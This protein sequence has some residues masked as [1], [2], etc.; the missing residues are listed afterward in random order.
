M[1]VVKLSAL[2]TGRLYPHEIFLVLISV[3]GWVD[4]RA[5]VRPEE[6]VNEKFQWH[7]RESKP[8]PSGLQ[9]SASTN[10]PQGH[11]FDWPISLVTSRR[12]CGQ[13]ELPTFQTINEP[14]GSGKWW[15]HTYIHTHTHTYIH[16]I[17]R[18]TITV[19]NATEFWLPSLVL[20]TLNRQLSTK[21]NFSPTWHL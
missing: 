19:I 8:R 5:I 16:T 3:R 10:C 21:H 20:T 15:S 13:L 12:A 2:R 17:C 18:D 14:A 6:Y 4:P 11:S 9:R 1:K 7:H